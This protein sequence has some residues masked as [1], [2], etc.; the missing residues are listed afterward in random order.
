VLGPP[1]GAGRRLLALELFRSGR[2]TSRG[3]LPRKIQSALQG[4]GQPLLAA[5]TCALLLTAATWPLWRTRHPT[6]EVRN[7]A[8]AAAEN[9]GRRLPNA[10]NGLAIF[11]PR[12]GTNNLQQTHHD[13][14]DHNVHQ[15]NFQTRDESPEGDKKPSASEPNRPVIELSTTTET[16]GT[17]LRLQTGAIVRGKEEKRPCIVMPPNGLAIT[18]GKVRFENVD[19]VWRQRPEEIASP[20]R[21]ALI[22]LRA[23]QTEFEGCTFQAKATGSFELPAAIRLGNN[24]QRGADLAP[25]VRVQLDRCVI[26]GVAC[27]VDCVARGPTS[28]TASNTLYTG[29]GPLVRFPQARR[30][31]ASAEISLQHVTLRSAAAAIELRC[32]DEADSS[33]TVVVNTTACVFA[34][35]QSGGLVIF[36]GRRSPKVIGGVLAALDW[37]CQD[38][39]V[40]PGTAVAIWQHDETKETLPDE[41]LP[42]EGLVASP[43]DFASSATSEPADSRLRRWLAPMR[44][45]LTPGIGDDLPQLP[46]IQTTPPSDDKR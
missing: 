38:S 6:A 12:S 7:T 39:L 25:A 22:E 46:D 44:T 40:S 36:S 18:V 4:A 9:G 33:G 26:E 24:V 35:E 41:E 2:Q 31:D 13:R 43:F 8:S 17:T 3:D 37:S 14:A 45:D 5:T 19:F 21:H 32:N 23:A 30:S 20:D 16:V 34:P 42:L 28:I 15:A 29:K 27:G 10:Q 1:S 11:Q